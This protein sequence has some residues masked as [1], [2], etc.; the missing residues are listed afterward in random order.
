MRR[1]DVGIVLQARLG[2][3]RLPGKVMKPLAGKPMVEWIIGRLQQ[4]TRAGSL[5][6]ATTALPRDEPLVALA[7]QLG[8]AVFR[9]SEPDVLDRYYRCSLAYGLRHVVR[10]TADNP[11]VDPE[12]CDRLVD[13]YFAR[14]LDYAGASTEPGVGYP[15]GVGVQVISAAALEQSWREGRAPHHREHVD[16]YILENPALFRQHK[17]A[18]PPEKRAAELSMTVD[19][20]SQFAFAAAVYA[21]HLSRCAGT[22]P[23]VAWAIERYRRRRAAP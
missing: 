9:G 21:R 13:F 10:A 11:F 16:E 3:Q 22:S 4:C 15:L 19:T 6:L 23:P 17:L 5:I 2:S 8:V 12:E 18:A 14:R 20:A 1:P 7:Q